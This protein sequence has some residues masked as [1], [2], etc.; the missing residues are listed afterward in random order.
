MI[1]QTTRVSKQEKRVQRKLLIIGIYVFALIG[2]AATGRVAQAPAS[3]IPPVFAAN[4]CTR[5]APSVKPVDVNCDVNNIMVNGSYYTP[6]TALRDYNQIS[7]NASRCWDLWYVNSSIYG[8]GCGTFG[9]IYQSD[10]YRQAACYM[11]GSNVY[12]NCTTYWHD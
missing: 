2:G 8:T 11:S 6:G 1:R 10:G 9:A 3:E 5:Y 12:G 7:L 4:H